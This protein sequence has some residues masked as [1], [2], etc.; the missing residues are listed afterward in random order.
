MRRFN[1]LLY[2]VLSIVLSVSVTYSTTYYSQGSVSV[3]TFS[4]WNTNPG[5]GGSVPASYSL[6]TDVF[7]VQYPDSMFTTATWNVTGRVYVNGGFLTYQHNSSVGTLDIDGDVYVQSGTILTVNNGNSTGLGYDLAVGWG[8]TGKIHNAGSVTLGSGASGNV[9]TGSTYLHN[10]NG[11]TIPSLVW[12][13][14]STC[15]I[16]G[17]T[18]TLPSGLTQSFGYIIYDSPS[19]SVDVTLSN[20][21]SGITSLTINSTGSA[22]FILG[23]NINPSTNV[24]INGG[25]F[26][27]STFTTAGSSNFTLASGATL[28]VGGMDNFPNTFGVYTLASNSIVEYYYGGTKTVAPREYGILRVNGISQSTYNSVTVKDSMIVTGGDYNTYGYSLTIA[29]SAVLRLN[30]GG[31]ISGSGPIYGTGSTLQYASGGTYDRSVEWSSISGAG[32]PYHVRLTN[33]TTLNLG[34]NS[35][36]TT[37]KGVAG[38]LTIDDGGFLDMSDVG[39]EMTAPLIV[40]GSL[41]LYGYL[42]LSTSTGGDIEVGGDWVRGPFSWFTQYGRNLTFNGTV[43][44]TIDA[45]QIGDEENFEKVYVDKPSGSLLVT[46]DLVITGSADTVLKILDAGPM[47]LDSGKIMTFN[48]SGGIIHVEGGIRSILG[49]ADIFVTG[50]KTVTGSGGGSLVFGDSI[51]L[52]LFDAFNFGP[53]ISTLNGT[54]IL[55]SISAVVSQPPIY[56]PSSVLSYEVS[57]TYHRGAEWSATSG[58]GYPHHVQI[59]SFTVLNLGNGGTG[60]A[61]QISGDLKINPYGELRMNYDTFEMTAPLTVLGSIK[62][63]GG[64]SLST[65]PGGS[66]ILAGDY[67][68]NGTLTTNNASFNLIGSTKQVISSDNP[69]YITFDSLVIASA[70]TVEV[71]YNPLTGINIGTALVID[72]GVLNINGTVVEMYNGSTLTNAGGTLVPANHIFNFLGAGTISGNLAFD[73]LKVHGAVNVG[74]SVSIISLLEIDSGGYIYNNAPLYGTGSILRYNT[75][76]VFGRSIEWSS[77]SGAGYPYNVEITGNTDLALGDNS[78]TTTARAIAGNLKVFGGSNLN[79]NAYEVEMTAPLTVYGNVEIYSGNITLSTFTGNTFNI[80]GNITLSDAAL[81]PN[82]NMVSFIGTG[83]STID[84][85]YSFDKLKIEKSSGDVILASG[86]ILVNDSLFFNGGQINTGFY[87]VTI[88]DGG[89]IARKDGHVNGTM[90]HNFPVGTGL[91]RTFAIG[92]SATYAP[93]DVTFANVYTAGSMTASTSTTGPLVTGSLLDSA[94]T[95]N[96]YWNLDNNAFSFDAFD[97]TFRFA[98]GDIDGGA[99]PQQ[100]TLWQYYD[101]TWFDAP[102]GTVT[103]S[104]IQGA[105]LDGFGKFT[106]GQLISYEITASANTGG[107]ITPIGSTLVTHGDDAEYTIVSDPGYYISDVTVDGGSIGITKKYFFN[108]VAETHTID[109]TFSPVPSPIVSEYNTDPKTL[110]LLRLNEASGDIAFDFS[111]NDNFGTAYGPWI[112]SGRIGNARGFDGTHK[113]LLIETDTTLYL[114]NQFT[115]E[116]WIKIPTT[117]DSANR[118]IFGKGKDN[119]TTAYQ[120]SLTT[121]GKLHIY[122][123]ND[124]STVGLESDDVL[125]SGRWNHVAATYNGSDLRLFINGTESGS[126][127]VSKHIL[128]SA[129]PLYIGKSLTNSADSYF[130]GEIDE[131]RISSIARTASDFNLQL[132]PL[133]LAASGTGTTIYLDWLNGGGMSPLMEYTIYRGADSTSMTQISTTTN[134]SYADSG[135]PIS[136]TFYYRISAVDSTGVES[137]PSFAVSAL[138]ADIIPPAAPAAL[139]VIDSM[140]SSFL[141][142]WNSSDADDFRAYLIYGGTNPEALALIDSTTM[143]YDTTRYIADLVI[144][145]KYYFTVTAADTNSNESEPSNMASATP[146]M[147]YPVNSFVFGNGTVDPDS[148]I[149]VD[150][151][152]SVTF[153][154]KANAFHHIDSVVIDGE[155]FLI[156]AITSVTKTQKEEQPSKGATSK[157]KPADPQSLTSIVEFVGGSSDDTLFTYTFYSVSSPH[158]IA[159]FFSANP[160]IAPYF[161]SALPDTAIPRFDSL[162]FQYTAVDPE[163]A[164]LSYLFI[165]GPSG[166]SFDTSTGVLKYLPAPGANGTYAVIVQIADDSTVTTDTAFVRVNIYGDVSGNGTISAFD[167]SHVLRHVVQID[168]LTIL[169]QRVGDVTGDMTI[170]AFDAS[171]ILQ[172]TVGLISSFPGGLGKIAQPEAI[173]SAFSFRIDKAAE[174]DHYDLFVSVNK[175]S[176]VFGAAMTLSF[177]STVVSPLAAAKTALTD[178]MMMAFHFPYQK[179]HMALAGMRPMN[180][181]GDIIKFTFMLKD[182]NYPKNAVLFTMDRFILNETD[183]TN[184]VGGITL[185][186]RGPA[187]LPTVY[188]LSQNFPNPFNPAT[189]INYQLPEASSVTITIYNTLGQ[190]VKRLVNEQQI[191]GYYSV[192]WN[193]TNHDNRSV[194]SGMYIYRIEAA[195]GDGAKF[196]QVKKM[197]LLK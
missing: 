159:G 101:G 30:S 180:D 8:S 35:G 85:L 139:A 59:G 34:A 32:Y 156:D 97:A 112:V 98:A 57:G 122:M 29:D 173:L 107:S 189:T 176:N 33:N 26:D 124:T 158:N 145:T 121:A 99:D 125:Q 191:A 39:I 67:L 195:G 115:F 166:A 82:G 48:N 143:A 16:N 68:H 88:A 50:S 109:V 76:G 96:R 77:T 133:D 43:D 44:Q 178:S 114:T 87:A 197:M 113:Y 186:V 90:R 102:E 174:P 162:T 5:G 168:T 105:A 75:G 86:D 137:V 188:A 80:Q 172:Y 93:V 165:E 38:D 130:N 1:C 19:Q 132:R 111:G 49:Y 4:N 153:T 116:A 185:N 83:N 170:S 3:N 149:F 41:Y 117:V 175:P 183:H 18:T 110:V 25:I 17:V 7:V 37:P 6:S 73:N 136:T 182:R 127:S 171:N 65:L 72:S 14:F 78:G 181:A 11:G 126:A 21:P 24:T 194:A 141:L 81:Y 56:G 27:L 151:G 36:N 74:S 108:T 128:N 54:L 187:E 100:F 70:D 196:S 91:S 146:Y 63:Y 135:L 71:P 138:T 51:T 161:T 60:V 167:A 15:R 119:L 134:L 13:P 52:H 22:K 58:A 152:D 140:Q 193:G 69:G 160:N 179:A 118:V 79:M 12:D 154:I 148:T 155:Y 95:L 40:K 192:Q 9:K 89:V 184:D 129:E 64:L 144:G 131:V 2:T 45:S 123:D 53:A 142:Q 164:A 147:Y 10:Q 55:Q 20:V 31:S 104:T 163:G 28:R 66:L 46:C 169:Q 190:E 106:A 61:R 84:G 177:D 103:D 62:N 120:L 94:K 157:Q 92:D 42:Y 23:A 47:I 150:H